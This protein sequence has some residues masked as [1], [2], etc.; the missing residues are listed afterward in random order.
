MDGKLRTIEYIC[1]G[2]RQYIHTQMNMPEVGGTKLNSFLYDVFS[3]MVWGLRL[4]SYTSIPAQTGMNVV[5]SFV[6]N[7]SARVSMK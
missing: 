6:S 2:K 7:S 1:C 4:H 3:I 5:E